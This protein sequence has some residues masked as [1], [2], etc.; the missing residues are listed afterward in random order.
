MQR[1]DYVRWAYRRAVCAIKQFIHIHPPQ[2]A[3]EDTELFS[4]LKGLVS[5]HEYDAMAG[6]F[7]NRHRK[8]FGDVDLRG[9]STGRHE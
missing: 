1:L 5:N 8:L 4:K 2:A 3:R 7:E 6:L 9:S